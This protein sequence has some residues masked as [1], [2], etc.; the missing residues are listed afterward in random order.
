MK[1][2]QY[3]QATPAS[4]RPF[5][6]LNLLA[7]VIFSSIFLFTALQSH[8]NPTGIPCVGVPIEDGDPCTIDAC[9]PVTGIITHVP[10][11]LTVNP[12]V[13]SPILCNGGTT[14]VDVSATGGFQPYNGTG[15]LCNYQEG[16]YEFSVTDD[17]GCVATSSI[18][19]ISQPTK[20]TVTATTN[21]TPCGM[22]TG[23]GTAT[24]IDGTPG[25]TYEWTD[26]NNSPVSNSDFA[27]PLAAGTY[28]V[29]ATDANG[30]TATTTAVVQSI[31][32]FPA[33]PSSISGPS[34]VCKGQSNVE[35]CVTAD[36]TV[37][38][39][40]WTLPAGATGSSTGNCINVSFNTKYTGGMIC[41]YAVN[42]C[43]SSGTVCISAPV[44]TSKSPKPS[45]ITGPS[46]VCT[47]TVNT[48]CVSSIPS[49]AGY[50]WTIGGN[51][52]SNP[53]TIVSGQGTPCVVVN[54]PAG[55]N[56]KQQLKV[57]AHNCKGMSD[58]R[59]LNIKV[60]PL[61]SMPS[62]I[63]GP[64]S[65]CMSQLGFYAVNNVNGVTYSWSVTGNVWIAG[66][67]GTNNLALD[68]ITS[69]A[70]S[71]VLSVT[72]ENQCGTS[73]ARTKTIAINTGCRMADRDPST[74]VNEK[75]EYSIYPNPARTEVN[76]DFVSSNDGKCFLT[77]FDMTGKVVKEAAFN[78]VS[79]ENHQLIDLQDVAKGAYLIRVNTSDNQFIS[80]FFIE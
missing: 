34:G 49:A 36:P 24:A 59:K 19:Q 51:G 40:V 48:Y 32:N 64:S 73:P 61:P 77:L 23:D 75:I 53:L 4:H 41:V 76:I 29:T 15:V 55:Y 67:Q 27:S 54:V 30:C 74:S 5:R 35:F 8:A 10:S 47:G 65:V 68:F 63:S 58:E 71:A 43:G 38:N 6:W 70:N 13:T 14:C 72:A 2:I 31:G 25:Y 42:S 18:I 20:V 11:G 45:A 60:N 33:T 21:P 37:T 66:G 26:Q 50:N 16:M 28:L 80:R 78:S 1:T 69:N 62:S 44:L 7:T 57:R 9:D 17:K 56:G 39:Y 46:P 52:G 12:V 79:G 22:I 3:T